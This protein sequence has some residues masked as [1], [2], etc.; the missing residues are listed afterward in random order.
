MLATE[1]NT[2]TIATVMPEKYQ[3]GCAID[4]RSRGGAVSVTVR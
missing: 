1:P 2:N 4:P 3:V